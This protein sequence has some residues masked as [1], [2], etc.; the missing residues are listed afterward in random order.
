MAVETATIRV[1]RETRDLLAS[2]ARE[3]GIS[4]SAML[5]EL[6]HEAAREAMFQSEREAS[7]ADSSNRDARVEENDWESALSD[8]I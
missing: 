3:R 1:T 5:E 6:A 2:Q 8:G 7:R 4:L